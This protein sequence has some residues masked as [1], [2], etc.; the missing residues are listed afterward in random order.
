M[1]LL[2]I[3]K[4]S[5]WWSSDRAAWTFKSRQLPYRAHEV[6]KILCGM[7]SGGRMQKRCPETEDTRDIRCSRL[8]FIRQETGHRTALRA[9]AG[10]SF[11]ERG[12]RRTVKTET[13]GTGG[14]QQSLM[15]GEG[16]KV[17]SPAFDIDR[18]VAD[19]LGRVD[20]D[21]DFACLSL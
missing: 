21:G 19:G 1:V 6:E 11:D 10:S 7:G 20:E 15:A 14:P 4:S 8:E 17:E 12:K 18:M 9:A 16:D 13:A 5:P 2:V 3:E